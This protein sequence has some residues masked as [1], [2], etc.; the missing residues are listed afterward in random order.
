MCLR[1]IRHM[2][3]A[4]VQKLARALGLGLLVGLQR[5]WTASHI[6]LRTF[7]LIT[8]LGAVLGL[9]APVLGKWL[10]A[11]GLLAVAALLIS[12]R[13][14]PGSTLERARAK[15]RITR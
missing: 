1:V 7:G 11:A 15:G 10:V 9:L 3:F 12:G 4:V 6:G 5:E 8:V 2:D 14:A 13:L